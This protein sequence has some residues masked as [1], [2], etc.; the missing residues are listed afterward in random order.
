MKADR[1]LTTFALLLGLA[2]CATPPS[3]PTAAQNVMK[4]QLAAPAPAP[5]KASAME[6]AEADT[7][8]K[9]Y[10]G[11]LGKPLGPRVGDTTSTVQ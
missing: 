6:G 7:V 5:E 2:A 10:I 1:F 11:R 8:Y 3:G 9:N 4:A